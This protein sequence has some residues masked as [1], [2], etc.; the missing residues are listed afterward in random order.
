MN[1]GS[2]KTQK[3]MD[4]IWPRPRSHPTEKG[5][6]PKVFDKQISGF[7]FVQLYLRSSFSALQV[8]TPKPAVAFSQ[9]LAPLLGA[10]DLGPGS[11]ME[12]NCKRAME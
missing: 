8:S 5:I 2:Y 6:Y 7:D 3:Y 12:A 4:F 10:L 1:G 9:G 11:A